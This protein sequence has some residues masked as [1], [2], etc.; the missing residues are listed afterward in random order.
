M[1]CTGQ[2]QGSLPSGRLSCSPKPSL[3]SPACLALPCGQPGGSW[4]LLVVPVAHRSPA[5]ACESALYQQRVR[6]G[7]RSLRCPGGVWRPGAGLVLLP[8]LP[9]SRLRRA[10]AHPH[11]ALPH[12]RAVTTSTSHGVASAPSPRSRIPRRGKS[13]RSRA[14]PCRA[15]NQPR[16][17]CPDPVPG[18]L[19]HGAAPLEHP[20]CQIFPVHLPLPLA[21]RWIWTW[22]LDAAGP[23]AGAG[24]VGWGLRLRAGNCQW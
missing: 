13:P 12:F 5:V 16:G 14:A 1:F 19:C 20:G 11:C 8:S 18:C 7:C 4:E 2:C 17:C 6:G 21:E 24:L 15:I 22:S 23:A 3:V 10:P 9:P